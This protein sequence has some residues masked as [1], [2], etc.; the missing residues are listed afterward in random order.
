MGE[1]TLVDSNILL[2]LFTRD[3]G[4]GSWSAERLA[5][6]VDRGPV[7]INQVIYAEISL[8]FTTVEALDAALGDRFVRANLPWPAGFLATRCFR[9]YRARGG[10]RTSTLPDFLIGAHAAVLGL[11]LLSRDAARYRTYFPTVELISP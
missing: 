10:T 4:W 11:R 6:A 2:D 9:E 3:P 1:A 7:V 5:E 8:R